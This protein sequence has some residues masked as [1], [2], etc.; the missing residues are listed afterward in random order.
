MGGRAVKIERFLDLFHWHLYPIQKPILPLPTT[1]TRFARVWWREGQGM[2][3]RVH[4]HCCGS[5]AAGTSANAHHR[6]SPA[7]VPVFVCV[8]VATI[9]SYA[10]PLLLRYKRHAARAPSQ[11]S[12]GDHPAGHT[13]FLVRSSFSPPVD[14]H[15]CPPRKGFVK[16][17]VSCLRRRFDKTTTP[18]ERQPLRPRS[19]GEQQEH[20]PRRPWTMVRP[21]RPPRELKPSPPL[22]PMHA[23]AE[24]RTPPLPPK[25]R[26][27]TKGSPPE[28]TR[29]VDPY[30][31]LDLDASLEDDVFYD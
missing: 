18:E 21:P 31:G 17:M 26:I 1:N 4:S 25:T 24:E 14:M 28:A 29:T 10:P 19:I 9:D 7:H 23:I 6:T 12:R 15:L 30:E 3:G 13:S 11:Y 16:R 27:C 5:R 20:V 22:Q 2:P 8:R